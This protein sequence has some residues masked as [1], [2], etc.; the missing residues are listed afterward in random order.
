MACIIKTVSLNAEEEQFLKDYK[1][2]PTAL[3]K[4]K[5]Q[6]MRGMLNSIAERKIMKL[7]DI[8]MEKGER[9][10][11]LELLNKN[12]ILEQKTQSRN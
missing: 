8:I 1:L 9:I 11:E 5:L 2:S 12:G 4:E 6:E 10:E 3:L 7:Q